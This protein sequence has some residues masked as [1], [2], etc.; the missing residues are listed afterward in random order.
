MLPPISPSA[1][2]TL[3]ARMSKAAMS[4]H[5]IKS[6]QQPRSCSPEMSSSRQKINS[7]NAAV[8][9]IIKLAHPVRYFLARNPVLARK[10]RKPGTPTMPHK[11]QKPYLQ[12]STHRSMT[13]ILPEIHRL[14]LPE[15]PH[16]NQPQ[17]TRYDQPTHNAPCL[18]DTVFET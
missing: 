12:Y 4:C 5:F 17:G 6:H 10:I 16:R 3:L 14:T 15:T 8:P 13:M 9:A 11:S 1:C 18:P 2:A 7:P